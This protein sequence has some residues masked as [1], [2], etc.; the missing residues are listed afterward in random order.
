MNK[1]DVET[2]HELLDRMKTF[3]W[4]NDPI[5]ILLTI[6]DMI[7]EQDEEIKKNKK[8]EGA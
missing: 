2:L 8:E 6:N 4:K 5:K 7:F 3:D 1:W